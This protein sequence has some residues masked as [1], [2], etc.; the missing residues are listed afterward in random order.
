MR[1]IA[2]FV[3]MA[4]RNMVKYGRRSAQSAAAI[5]IGVF[6]VVLAGAFL[7]GFAFSITQEHPAPGR[8]QTARAG[9]TIRWEVPA[10]TGVVLRIQPAP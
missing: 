7:S 2:L 1:N 5:F 6:F 3:K 8:A 4:A 9:E 10:Q